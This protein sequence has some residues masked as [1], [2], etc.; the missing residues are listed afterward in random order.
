MGKDHLEALGLDGRTVLN[1][2]LK[3]Y[4]SKM[5]TQFIWLKVVTR[6]F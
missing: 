1:G 2:I 4:D 3:K 5:Y 6:F